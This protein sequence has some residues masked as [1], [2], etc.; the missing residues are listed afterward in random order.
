MSWEYKQN[1]NIYEATRNNISSQK[2]RKLYKRHTNK[3][4]C[5]FWR[6]QSA[7]AARS[8][9]GQ[10]AARTKQLEGE[11]GAGVEYS[12]EGNGKKGRDKA[13]TQK[14]EKKKKEREG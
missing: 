4:K 13:Q 6:T 2:G 11:E 5:C 7:R 12:G 8:Q 9:E 3:E 14:N 1:R 10:I